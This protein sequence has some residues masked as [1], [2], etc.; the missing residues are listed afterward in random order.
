MGVRCDY[1]DSLQQIRQFVLDEL[2]RLEDIGLGAG[3]GNHHLAAA[4]YQ[5]DDLGVVES[6]D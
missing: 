4:E 6:V 5:A 3:T 1:A 2:D